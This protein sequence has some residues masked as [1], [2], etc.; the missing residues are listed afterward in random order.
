MAPRPK[1]TLTAMSE[2]A[3]QALE[4][5]LAR[6]LRA[7][8]LVLINLMSGIEDS[9]QVIGWAGSHLH[10]DSGDDWRVLHATMNEVAH[11]GGITVVAKGAPRV[12]TPSPRAGDLQVRA[13]ENRGAM[14]TLLASQVAE[15]LASDPDSAR[16][17]V[18]ELVS[19]FA[20]EVGEIEGV[21]AVYYRVLD[22]PKSMVVRTVVD[23]DDYDFRALVYELEARVYDQYPDY[24]VDFLLWT[25]TEAE[26]RMLDRARAQG[27]TSVSRGPRRR[28]A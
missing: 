15:I 12:V 17:A 10:P 24:T 4:A 6:S 2:H 26:P 13:G 11:L 1:R 7:A 14:S 9:L 3:P 19:W 25:S 5:R 21:V 23:K 8:S 18:P 22:A 20:H 16:S 28:A 27:F